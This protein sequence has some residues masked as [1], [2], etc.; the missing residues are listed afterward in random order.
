MATSASARNVGALSADG[1]YSIFRSL[2]K[3]R[4]A[5]PNPRA[6]RLTIISSR[7]SSTTSNS[8]DAAI[9]NQFEAYGV[10]IASGLGECRWQPLRTNYWQRQPVLPRLHVINDWTSAQWAFRPQYV[11]PR[12][13]NGTIADPHDRSVHRQHRSD[14]NTCF[15]SHCVRRALL[16]YSCFH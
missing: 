16:R 1:R 3:R 11:L 14:W 15:I 5:R 10:I 6:P 4:P 9:P 2:S 12:L 8:L 13:I 7:P